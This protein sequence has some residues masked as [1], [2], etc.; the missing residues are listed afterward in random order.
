MGRELEHLT[1]RTIGHCDVS[2]TRRYTAPM[3][4]SA[5]MS[6]IKASLALTV[7][8]V[9]L[10][11]RR[12]DTTYLLRHPGLF[13][14]S[15]LAMNVLMPLLALWFTIVFALHPVV[16]V[17]LIALALS[18]V[19]PFLPNKMSRAGGNGSYVVGLF[20]AASLAAIVVV[21][22]SASL[23]GS[24]FGVPFRMPPIE[25]AKLVGA[26]VLVPVGVGIAIRRSAPTAAARLSGPVT[27]LSTIVLVVAIIPLLV[28]S[29]PAMRSLI[30][31]GTLVAIVAM[32]I[33]GLAVGH[34][35]GGPNRDDRVVLALATASRHP[36]VA[37]AIATA[38]FPGEKLIPAAV[39]LA[40]LVSAL[41]SV[42]Y[43]AWS[44][45]WSRRP[46]QHSV[47]AAR[48]APR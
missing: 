36:A 43:T 20:V 1:D 46:S 42:P 14:Q 32:T 3:T 29:W 27:R 26:S 28:S 12:G 11:S 48:T 25:I 24:L 13:A 37:I 35:L 38:S 18:P 17:A 22:F 44:R 9:G 5:I 2:E 45:R 19:P 47:S 30:G 41:V 39:V 7:L 8:A 31:N 40:L 21:P 10:R 4:S 34:A 23:L 6:A 33:A 16:K 15:F